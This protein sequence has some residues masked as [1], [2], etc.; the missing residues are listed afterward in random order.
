MIAM[1]LLPQPDLI[2]LDEPTSGLDVT[3]A[4]AVIDLIAELRAQFGTSL[5]FISHN[6]KSGGQSLRAH[7]RALCR[8]PGRGHSGIREPEASLF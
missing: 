1:A 2:L 4:V 5:P 6:L 8:R 7:R 3:V